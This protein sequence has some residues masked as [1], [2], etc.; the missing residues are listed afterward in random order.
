[1][2]L[3]MSQIIS[4]SK[5]QSQRSDCCIISIMMLMTMSASVREHTPNGHEHL[6]CQ[7]FAYICSLTST[8][9]AL[10]LIL[11]MDENLELEDE[12]TSLLGLQLSE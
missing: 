8:Y 11:M 1:M 2:Q 6:H 7:V 4:N 5:S 12:E 10:Q 3:H 9:K